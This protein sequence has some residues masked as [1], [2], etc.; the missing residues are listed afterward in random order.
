MGICLAGIFFSSY[1]QQSYI[2]HAVQHRREIIILSY[3]LSVFQRVSTHHHKII[4]LLQQMKG[5]L[6]FFLSIMGLVCVTHGRPLTPNLGH[7]I[8][9]G[10]FL[11]DLFNSSPSFSHGSIKYNASSLQRLINCISFPPNVVLS[12]KET[13]ISFLSCQL[14]PKTTIF[15]SHV[16]LPF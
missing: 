15:L 3:Y 10:K 12:H 11:P 5:Q 4:Q 8:V 9:L 13:S 16:T 14:V 2:L 6:F 7:A 1:I